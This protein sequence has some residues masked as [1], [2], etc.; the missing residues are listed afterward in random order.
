MDNIVLFF[1]FFDEK[2]GWEI[3][4]KVKQI[5]K[6]QGCTPA[7]VAI[8]WLLS[9]RHIVLVGAKTLQQFDENLGALDVN[10]TKDQL[11]QL[12]ELT[13][14]RQMY[15]DCM[16]QRKSSGREFQILPAGWAA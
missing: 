12:E 8:S 15:P 5:G 7:Q 16:I 1:P 3:V 9:K 4:E 14:P 6:G 11:V 13:K 10:L 2:T